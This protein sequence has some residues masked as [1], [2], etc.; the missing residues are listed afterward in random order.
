MILKEGISAV[1]KPKGPTSHDIIDEIRRLT[2][3]R[4]VGHAGTLD[5]LAEGVLVVGVGATATK[6]LGEMVGKEKEYL[7][8]IWLGITS[9]TDDEEGV[10]SIIAYAI[11]PTIIKIAYAI[12][13][14]IGRISQR[15][16]IYSAIKI[17]GRPAYASARA[18]RKIEL[19]PRTVEIKSIEI[20]QYVWPK[21]VLKVICGPGVYI[22]SLARDLGEK[23]GTGGYLCELTRTRVGEF[24]LEEAIKLPSRQAPR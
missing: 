4:K 15:P 2:G 6:R 20:L 8:T 12:N 13:Q 3:I 1:F 23:L 5:P 22:R 18:G 9:T 7:A 17:K 11:A 19:M 21:L 10:K 16:P 24:R 14:L